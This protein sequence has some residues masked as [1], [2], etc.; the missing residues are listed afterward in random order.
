MVYPLLLGQGDTTVAAHNHETTGLPARLKDEVRHMWPLVSWA[1]LQGWAT[2][3]ASP[4]VISNLDYRSEPLPTGPE[5]LHG[6]NQVPRE[7]VR[8]DSM[9]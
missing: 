2:I 4:R 7:G 1:R 8:K 5:P 9:T 6:P 3:V